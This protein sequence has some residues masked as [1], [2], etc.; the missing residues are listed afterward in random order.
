MEH[1]T[2]EGWYIYQPHGS[3]DP[4]HGPDGRI[5]GVAGGPGVYT[6]IDGLTK[7]EARAVCHVLRRIAKGERPTM[8]A[9]RHDPEEEN[10]ASA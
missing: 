3:I 10:D 2:S 9:Y 7:P 1:R 8:V 5:F 6:K 4:V